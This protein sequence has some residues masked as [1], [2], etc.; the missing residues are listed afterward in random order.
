G[1]AGGRTGRKREREDGR[2]RDLHDDGD[3]WLDDEAG[4]GV[5]R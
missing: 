2:D 1:A 4:P 3:G 5:L